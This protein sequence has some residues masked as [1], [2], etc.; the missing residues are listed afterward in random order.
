[1][2]TLHTY[3][4]SC[5]ICIKNRYFLLSNL[6]DKGLFWSYLELNKNTHTWLAVKGILLGTTKQSPAFLALN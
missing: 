2:C 4:T 5:I 6:I 3:T 1:M